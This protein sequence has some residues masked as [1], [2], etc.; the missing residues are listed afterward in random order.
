MTTEHYH[1]YSS[2]SQL[3]LNYVEYN[4]GVFQVLYSLEEVLSELCKAPQ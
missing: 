2:I 3:K 1:M 4:D